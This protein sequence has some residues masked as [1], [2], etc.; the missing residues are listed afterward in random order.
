MYSAHG[1]ARWRHLRGKWEVDASSD[2][3]FGHVVTLLRV[4]VMTDC[5]Q[6]GGPLYPTRHLTIGTTCCGWMTGKPERGDQGRIYV[7]HDCLQLNAIRAYR[8]RHVQAVQAVDHFWLQN[9]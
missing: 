1:L 4:A 9:M 2:E 8:R 7:I 5:A 6:N 3:L